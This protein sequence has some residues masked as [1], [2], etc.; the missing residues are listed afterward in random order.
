MK[1]TMNLRDACLLFH[2]LSRSFE[3]IVIK[4]EPPSSLVINT[5]DPS[6]VIWLNAKIYENGETKVICGDDEKC[7][8]DVTAI[9]E[10]LSFHKNEARGRVEFSL[11]D[12]KT[13]M[14]VMREGFTASMNLSVPLLRDWIAEN[15][16]FMPTVEYN[17]YYVKADYLCRALQIC[18]QF[19][20][21]ATLI[22][23]SGGTLFLSCDIERRN[24]SLRIRAVPVDISENCVRSEV[25]IPLLL[26]AL[27]GAGHGDYGDIFLRI[28]Q[29]SPIVADFYLGHSA[30]LLY[31]IAPYVN[32][33]E[34]GA[35]KI[36]REAIEEV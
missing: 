23:D 14:S 15:E 35:D 2:N 4:S 24:I 5:M 21:K 29:N 17:R 8:L 36:R 33:T 25:Y 20:E 31:C 28:G 18:D 12:G 30:K 16:G 9:C 19:T 1:L 22:S 27:E 10:F 11:K 32:P 13:I 34:F 3:E 7:L 6:H 26:D